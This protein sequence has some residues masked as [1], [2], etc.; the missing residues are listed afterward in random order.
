M[1]RIQQANTTTS[2]GNNN[3]WGEVYTI[4]G[5][6]PAFAA[7]FWH[8]S[9]NL[10]APSFRVLCERVGGPLTPLVP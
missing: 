4:D 10:G 6:W 7:Q 1:N 2:T 9:K 3:C 5:G 8:G